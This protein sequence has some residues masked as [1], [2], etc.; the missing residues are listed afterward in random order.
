MRSTFLPGDY[1]A[2]ES[3]SIRDIHLGDVVVYGGANYQNESD[4][5]AH[6][7]VAV[8]P[9]GLV[10]RGDNNTYNDTTLVT[11][12]NL[13]GRVTHVQ[14]NGKRRLVYGR[15][16]G[17]LRARILHVRHRIWKLIKYMGCR[18]YRWLLNSSLIDRLWQPSVMKVR[19]K[20]ENGLLVK[21]VC[22]GKTVACWWPKENRFYCRIPYDLVIR[23]E[24]LPQ[25]AKPIT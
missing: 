22:E 3:I 10:T 25:Q 8:V 23:R 11:A 15:R 6:R 14:R 18:P 17:L 4:K 13:V 9:D 7:V 20:T 1:L 16:R 5:L 2:V 24:D 21:Y 12:E 19:L